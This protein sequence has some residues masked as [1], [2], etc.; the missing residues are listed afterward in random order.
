MSTTTIE[1]MLKDDLDSHS[2][3]QLIDILGKGTKELLDL[4]NKKGADGILIRDKR[5]EVQMIQ[6]FI[7][8]KK[9]GEKN[10]K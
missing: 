10:K 5:K 9:P 8:Q 4:M 2:L 3:L 1:P 6:E 7:N